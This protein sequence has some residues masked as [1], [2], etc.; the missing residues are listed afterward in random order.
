MENV[1]SY[2][3]GATVTENK[4]LA[5]LAMLGVDSDTPHPLFSNYVAA[6]EDTGDLTKTI[7][8]FTEFI[9]EYAPLAGLFVDI[10]FSDKTMLEKMSE[11]ATL[12][13]AN[14]AK[15][16]PNAT[17]TGTTVKPVVA[18]KINT[19]S[20][21]FY[22]PPPSGTGSGVGWKAYGPIDYAKYY[23]TSVLTAASISA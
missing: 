7:S 8:G 14:F 13:M 6:A 1:S 9:A 5:K 12:G 19:G 2:F 16:Y 3:S 20:E 17:Y 15:K 21:L 22:R 4:S 10:A 11:A 18:A 23:Q